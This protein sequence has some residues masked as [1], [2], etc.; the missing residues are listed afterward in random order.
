MTQPR[1]IVIVGGVA[2]GMSAAT[3]LRRLDERARITVIERGAAVSLAT[4]GM[5]YVIGGDIPARDAL[6]LQTPERLRERFDLDVRVRTE[7]TAIDRARRVLVVA[8]EAGVEELPYDDLVLATG[9]EPVTLDVPGGERALAL[10]GLDDLDRILAAADGARTAVVIGGGFVGLEVAENLH[11]RG[12][13]V[14]LVHRGRQLLSA[15]DPEMGVA[16]T[17]AARAA[18]V[19]VRL[20]VAPARIGEASVELSSGEELPAELVITA[21]GVRPASTLARE[22]GLA[23]GSA[24]GVLV[25]DELRTSDP[26]IRAVGDVAEKPDAVLGGTRSIPL[27]GPANHHGRLVADALAGLD[28]VVPP[29][30]GT[31]IVGAFGV[32][33][34][35][36]GA[37]EAQLVQAGIAHRVIHTHPANHVGYY[38]GAESMSLK[39]IVAVDDDR[40]LG[41]QAV[42]GA[43]VDRRIDVLATAMR[44]GVT[45][46]E[47]AGLELAYAPQFG[48]AKDPVNML[49]YVAQ[50][51]RDGERAVQWHELDAALASGARL[52]DVRGEAQLEEGGIPGAE[53]IPVEALRARID[54]LRAGPVV[55]HCRVGQGAHT[56]MK[57]LEAHGVDAANLD[58][59]YLTWRAAQRAGLIP[60]PEK[61]TLR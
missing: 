14:A 38:P 5:P 45:A 12:I 34:A 39:L 57:L 21:A 36:V 24:G 33:A 50:N 48:S 16:V 52:V 19:E 17:D 53:W 23:I 28:I 2:A 47:L 60:T 42:G 10:R 55:V 18:G 46:S 54:E 3:R 11:Q 29:T 15:L 13:R 27:A 22:A 59:G 49:G 43:G 7:A 26:A 40:I 31:A 8:S 9:A 58:G 20:G 41:A 61:E 25:D 32:V 56:A 6:L 44:A 4:C 30:L 37:T 1:R 51:R 35:V